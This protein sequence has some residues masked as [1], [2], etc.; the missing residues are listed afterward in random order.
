MVAGAGIPPGMA[1]RYRVMRI[2]MVAGAGIFAGHG[3]ALPGLAH[4]DGRGCGI[5][6]GM[7]RRYRVLRIWMVV[8]AGVPPGMARRYRVM[9][10]WMVAGAGISPG[11]AR[12]YP[13][14]AS[15][16]SLLASVRTGLACC[17]RSHCARS[18]GLSGR[19]YR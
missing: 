12:R 8:G 3:P 18:R 15:T 7:A 4:L 1:R 5:P 14:R 6:P 13:Q 10:I 9:H 19:E 11:V 16:T 17:W 2:W